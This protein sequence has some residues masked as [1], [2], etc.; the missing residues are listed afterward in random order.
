ML[1]TKKNLKPVEPNPGSGEVNARLALDSRIRDQQKQLTL[2]DQLVSQSREGI[3]RLR[4]DLAK[5]RDAR[6]FGG[7]LLGPKP[8]VVSAEEANRQRS[9]FGSGR[10]SGSVYEPSPDTLEGR[11]FSES[12]G[13][14]PAS[15]ASEGGPIQSGPGAAYWRRVI[16]NLGEFS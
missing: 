14:G 2:A 10:V 1:E 8:R 12:G 9:A 13:I 11:V 4:D 15:I 16:A 3:F 6:V 7:S 5:S